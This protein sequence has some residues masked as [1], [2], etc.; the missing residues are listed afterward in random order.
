[1]LTATRVVT[2]ALIA[3]TAAPNAMTSQ[4]GIGLAWLFRNTLAFD[5]AIKPTAARTPAVFASAIKPNSP[6]VFSPGVAKTDA[7]TQ[8][9][10]T[11]R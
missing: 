3:P 2:R 7:T 4:S 8:M 5:K 1:M 11:H 10:P 6:S 9:G